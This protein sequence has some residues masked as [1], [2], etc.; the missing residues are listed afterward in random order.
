[1]GTVGTPA[2]SDASLADASRRTAWV[3][4]I[5]FV[6]RERSTYFFTDRGAQIVMT[7]DLRAQ[8]R[9]LEPDQLYGVADQRFHRIMPELP[10][11][12]APRP[13]ASGPGTTG[14]YHVV[15]RR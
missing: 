11:M 6:P 4:A 10:A 5:V 9:L 13:L 14:D 15:G 3:N 12:P 8:Y 2:P 7:G 1:M